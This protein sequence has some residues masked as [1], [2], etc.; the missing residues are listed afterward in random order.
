MRDTINHKGES[1]GRE[2]GLNDLRENA[3]K[4]FAYRFSL[5]TAEEFNLFKA[6]SKNV[7]QHFGKRSQVS[8]FSPESPSKKPFDVKMAETLILN[9]PLM[10]RQ[11]S[12]P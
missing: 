8:N 5:S 2:T 3:L 10:F 11:S 7:K 12:L 4:P 1:E 9:T 6:Q